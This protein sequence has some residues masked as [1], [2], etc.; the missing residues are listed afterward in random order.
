MVPGDKT[1]SDGHKLKYKKLH[2]SVRKNFLMLRVEEHW[3][4]LPGKG[5]ESPSAE[6]FRTP[7]D[8]PGD[9]VLPGAW[10]G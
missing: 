6:T 9:L 2:L 10:T 1:R 8:A 5:V 4:V 7:L 3:N